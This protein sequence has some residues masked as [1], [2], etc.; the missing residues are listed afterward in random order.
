MKGLLS[1]DAFNKYKPIV[2]ELDT[3]PKEVKSLVATVGEYWDRYPEKKS[4][5]EDDLFVLYTSLY[6]KSKDIDFVK[7]F[8]A[9]MKE[10]KVDNPEVLTAALNTVVYRHFM[11]KVMSSA[12][13][14]L[15]THDPEIPGMI[16]TDIENYRLLA[17]SVKDPKGKVFK[18]SM[19]DIIKSEKSIDLQWRTPVLQRALGNPRPG[20]LHHVFG[21]VHSGKSLML[22]SECT[23]FARQMFKTKSEDS[24]MYITN[25]EGCEQLMP[26]VYAALLGQSIDMIYQF[27]ERAEKAYR[28]NGGEYVLVMDDIH[29][30]AQVQRVVE[31][32]RPKLLFIDQGTKVSMSTKG[33]SDAK[34]ELLQKVYY[35]YRKLVVKYKMDIVTCGQ[36]SD[37]CRHKKWL[38]DRDMDGAKIGMPG[39][40]DVAIGIGRDDREGY[41]QVRYL[42]IPKNR[43]NG[44]FE[45]DTV[46]LNQEKV[47]FE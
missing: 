24:V 37:D 17:G 35:E 27:P 19:M 4:V 14:G 25:E 47:R 5:A 6:P 33:K 7:K 32:I 39:E 29:H 15:D 20:R 26:R 42:N 21:H 34:H 40:L 1:Q 38:A 46:R 44:K 41:E 3:L 11:G 43:Y 12:N 23:W 31:S 9:D 28:E 10:I 2:A 8:V 13:K 18:K 36:A 16:V 45:R 30:L 22:I